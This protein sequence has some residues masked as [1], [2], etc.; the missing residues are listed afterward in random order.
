MRARFT[1]RRLLNL[2]MK[3]LAEM[4]PV[5]LFDFDPEPAYNIA[6]MR[7]LVLCD[8][9]RPIDRSATHS[10]TLRMP[11]ALQ[12][13]AADHWWTY[14]ELVELIDNYDA[15]EKPLNWAEKMIPMDELSRS[16]G[17]SEAR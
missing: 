13:G 3:E 8:S 14:E 9:G 4:L 11:P 15:T 12:A 16:D 17:K 10:G 7:G 2:V 1:L 6:P 5:G